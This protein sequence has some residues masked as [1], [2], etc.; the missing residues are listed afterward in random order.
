MQVPP[1]NSAGMV[2]AAAPSGAALLVEYAAL[3]ARRRRRE[4][5]SPPPGTPAP[6]IASRPEDRS[7]R[8]T[9]RRSPRLSLAFLSPTDCRN[10][11]IAPSLRQSASGW[12]LPSRPRGIVPRSV[13]RRRRWEGR[14][15]PFACGG[16][17]GVIGLRADAPRGRLFRDRRN[18]LAELRP[19]QPGLLAHDQFEEPREHRADAEAVDQ[20]FDTLRQLVE[21]SRSSRGWR[22]RRCRP[23]RARSRTASAARGTPATPRSSNPLSLKP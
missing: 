9:P 4:G 15:G 10:A 6:T 16:L 2:T 11:I 13:P 19:L 1:S 22:G 17:R 8:R 20:Q 21:R 23:R 12:I 14:T 18:E 7:R 5:R 3:K